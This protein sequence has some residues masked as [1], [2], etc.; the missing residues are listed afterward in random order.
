MHLLKTHC[1]V[2][3]PSTDAEQRVV[4]SVAGHSLL[5]IRCM[6][7]GFTLRYRYINVF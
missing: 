7:L 3:Q 4:P 5:C 6:T 1:P 2:N